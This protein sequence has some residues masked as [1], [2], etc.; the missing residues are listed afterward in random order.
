M[1]YLNNYKIFE[2]KFYFNEMIHYPGRRLKEIG[3]YIND[4]K[5][6]LNKVN[7]YDET[8]LIGLS[9]SL[10]N[11]YGYEKKKIKKYI[12][13]LIDK[14]ADL[15][16]ISNFNTNLFL[17]L[18]YNCTDLK[19][20]KK[21]ID[22]GINVYPIIDND[23]Y[24]PMHICICNINVIEKDFEKAKLIINSPKYS[25]INFGWSDLN[26]CLVYERYDIMK[27][28]I[29]NGAEFDDEFIGYIKRNNIKQKLI[30]LFPD[31]Y[32]KYESKKNMEKFNI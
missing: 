25:M 9:Y 5:N 12:N 16:I 2:N 19:L 15:N 13:L 14:G 32:E 23:K 29:D 11:S 17:N 7:P 24:S 31:E 3:D 26:T 21:T 8:L 4:D 10:K 6:N 27:L 20:I 30:E 28:L 18:I 1:K 22:K